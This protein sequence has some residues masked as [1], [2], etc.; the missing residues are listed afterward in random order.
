MLFF[1]AAVFMDE[2]FD[3]SLEFTL[4]EEGGFFDHPTDP[5]F[6]T[7]HG[8]T[9]ARLRRFLRDPALSRDDVRYL[10]SVTVRAMYLADFWNRTRCDAL[11]PG[12]DL[13]VFD[14]AVNAGP[15]R[16][17]RALQLAV[18]QKRAEIDGAVGPDT[19]QRVELADTLTLVDA[20]AAM[21]RGSYRQMAAYGLFGEG[22]LA[23]LDRRRTTALALMAQVE[24]LS[25]R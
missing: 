6:A 16:A 21:Q 11:P 9:L 7:N 17:G 3:A 24:P 4:A 23:R 12:L 13:M 19:L 2:S 1:S 8:I 5:R 22:W 25:R 14:H 20:L 18:G 10:P 15:D